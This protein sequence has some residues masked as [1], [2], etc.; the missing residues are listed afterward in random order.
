M[1]TSVIEV[2]DFLSVLSVLGVE[3][4]IMKVPGVESATVNFAA[5]TAT[6]RYDE[7]Q[8]EAA[9][10]KTAVHQSESHSTQ[11]SRVKHAKKHKSTSKP[12]VP[13]ETPAVKPPEAKVDSKAPAPLKDEKTKTEPSPK[14]GGAKGGDAPVPTAPSP[15]AAKPVNEKDKELSPPKPAAAKP[16]EQKGRRIPRPP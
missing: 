16:T 11:A 14:G 6:V 13:P 4:R 3:Q 1:K 12:A 5:G 7:T 15:V 10:I 9:D 8:L 2:R